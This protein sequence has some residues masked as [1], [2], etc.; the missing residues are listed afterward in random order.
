[1]L[2]PIVGEMGT[3]IIPLHS[4]SQFSLNPRWVGG[5]AVLSQETRLSRTEEQA[6]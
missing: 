6:R 3:D 4:R 1:M 2:R 5:T